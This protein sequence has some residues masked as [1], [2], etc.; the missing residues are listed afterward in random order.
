MKTRSRMLRRNGFLCSILGVALLGAGCIMGFLL[1][2]VGQFG[3]PKQDALTALFLVFAGTFF[4]SFGY[5]YLRQLR[6][7]SQS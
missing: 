6:K 5:L 7:E 1:L 4:L 2:S 3:I